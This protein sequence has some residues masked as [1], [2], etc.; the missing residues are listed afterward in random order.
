M[1]LASKTAQ[2]S[3]NPLPYNDRNMKIYIIS[4]A[5]SILA[6]LLYGVL[7]VRSPAPPVAALIGLFG[8]LMGEQMVPFAKKFIANPSFSTHQTATSDSKS[9]SLS[10]S[11][12]SLTTPNQHDKN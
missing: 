4:L 7:N 10:D 3:A 11:S 6:G 5:V 1:L 12:V 9:N 8:M 2:G